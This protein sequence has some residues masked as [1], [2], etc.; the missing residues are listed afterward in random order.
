[1]IRINLPR[2][3]SALLQWSLNFVSCLKANT[4]ILGLDAENVSELQ[5]ITAK[6]GK[7]LEK[8]MAV[9]RTKADVQRK[10]TAF[11]TLKEAIRMFVSLN[12]EYN[13][14]M[15]LELHYLMGLTP[16]MPAR[17]KSSV[18]KQKPVLEGK[19]SEGRIIIRYR[20][21]ENNRISKPKGVRIIMYRWDT[22]E[23]DPETPENLSNVETMSSG[24]LKLDFT[25]NQRGKPVYYSACWINNTGRHGPWSEIKKLYIA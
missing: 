5:S 9:N 10:N 16:G 22:L 3:A 25:E 1:M 6:L 23:C 15:T 18:P 8:S 24:S 2:T 13:Q 20:N 4:K 21:S 17:P 12:L 11:I 7:E 19:S 14:K